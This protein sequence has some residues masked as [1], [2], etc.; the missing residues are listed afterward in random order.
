MKRVIK[1]SA[2]IVNLGRYDKYFQVDDPATWDKTWNMSQEEAEEIIDWYRRTCD[3][4]GYEYVALI[5]AKDPYYANELDE[6]SAVI[7]GKDENGQLV[8]LDIVNDRVYDV[9]DQ[10][11]AIIENEFEV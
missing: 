4:Y 1:A 2:D 9:T 7:L 11:D 10:V 5:E 3:S 8:I 6:Y